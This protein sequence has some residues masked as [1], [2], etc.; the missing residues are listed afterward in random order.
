MESDFRVTVTAIGS[1]IRRPFGFDK[2]GACHF[3]ECGD[4]VMV[5]PS[6]P[7]RALYLFR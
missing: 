1:L 4:L 6:G 7:R 3:V 5:V 2:Q